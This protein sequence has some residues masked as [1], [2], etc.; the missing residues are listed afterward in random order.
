M[1]PLVDLKRQYALI[2]DEIKQTVD[3]TIDSMQFINGPQIKAFEAEFA[4]FSGARHGIGAS[5]GTTALQLALK[6]LDI[7][8]GDEVITVPN[9]FIATTEAITH[10]GARVVF[11]DVDERTY[12]IDPAAIEAAITPKTKAVIGV[13][14]YGQPC[15]IAAVTAVA[16][17]H[18]LKVIFDS[19]QAHLAE[20][21]GEPIGRY[22]DVIC[23]SFYPGKNL[24]AYGDGGIALTNDEEL[25]R[26]MFML[27]DHGRLDKYEHLMEGFNFR[28][29]E[30]QA[31][32]L[33]VKLKYLPEWTRSR[34]QCAARYDKML[35][36]LSIT[37]PYRD[38]RCTHVYHLYVIRVPNRDAVKSYLNERGIGAGV[39]YP[40]CLHLQQAYAHF[41]H[42]PGDFPVA[43]RC[44][45][46]ILSL[47][48]F[49]E[50]TPDD[51]LT[52]ISTL[53]EALAACGGSAQHV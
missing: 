24:G 21:G 44:A 43:E 7:G 4:R 48:M 17:R 29:S 8:P 52:V 53:K 36:E 26:K 5:S 16:D 14:L 35:T 15:D 39:H 13:H 27:A 9:T 46:E 23:Y 49:P 12:N 25:G 20:F 22:G 41:G 2:K 34:Q 30:V 18:G 3:Q 33:N 37:P 11:A 31:A 40:I 19:A 47:P 45:S 32:I 50:L 51:Q 10:S 28:L 6:A 38:E 1:I 42:K